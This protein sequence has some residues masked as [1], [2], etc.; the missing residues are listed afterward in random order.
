MGYTKVKAREKVTFFG[1]FFVALL[2]ILA[3]NGALPFLTSP[4]LGQAVWTTGF[5]QSFLNQALSTIYS[6]NFGI[7]EPAAIAF[8]LA[9]AFVTAVL[10]AAGLHAADAYSAMIAFWLIIAF[11]SAFKLARFVSVPP[12]LAVLSALAWCTMPMVWNHAGY[13]MVSTGIALLPLY[14][15]AALW[16]FN[17][18]Q[19][20][21]AS[22][23][24]KILKIFLF[25][26]AVCL[27][28][29]FM[30]GYTFM[31]FACGASIIAV[32]SFF[33]ETASIK[34]YS[35]RLSIHILSFGIAYVLYAL[36]LG[37]PQFEASPIDFFRGWGVDI[38]FWLI[39]S[40]GVHWIP[41]LLGLSNLRSGAQFFGDSSVWV[42][43]FALPVIL[44]AFTITFISKKTRLVLP[45]IL[46]TLFG[47][48]MAL[49]PS[50][51]F[52]SIKPAE[53]TGGQMMG[54][55]YAVAPTGT[56]VLSE[57]LPGFKNMRAS[58]RWQAL[59]V[60]GA[61]ALIVLAMSR[62]QRKSIIA[63][64]SVTLVFV[65]ILNLPNLPNKFV[66]DINHRTMFFDI[67]DQLVA[68]LKN[69]V[70]HGEKV[71]FLPWRNDFLVNYLA[72]KLDIRT[73]NIGGDKNLMEARRHWPGLLQQFQ[74]AKID[75]DFAE[76][77]ALVLARKEADAVILPYID[78][79]WAAHAWPAKL[80][81]KKELESVERKLQT[82]D[83][84]DVESSTY[85]SVIRLKSDNDNL[86]SAIA[87]II[88]ENCGL[89][90]LC[91]EA[92]EFNA[93][94]TATQVGIFENGILKSSHQR[95][96]LLY[97]P[98]RP[99]GAGEYLLQIHGRI[100]KPAQGWIDV[101]S[102]RGSVVHAKF[103]LNELTESKGSQL[104][105]KEIIIDNPLHDVEVRVFVT[106]ADSVSIES[107]ALRKN[108]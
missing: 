86:A 37:K 73:Y 29:V 14:L 34:Q 26:L 61:W 31:M 106:E 96:F 64:A 40:A 71:L 108:K 41:D 75:Q 36:Y 21:A 4:T 32:W 67:D 103:P 13:S 63:L 20:I 22:A 15:L 11:F 69:E 82:Y 94:I 95:G 46:I 100:D 7:P 53:Y 54:A 80:E 97:G 2:F 56:A 39:P 98:Y 59:G 88:D 91:V 38:A 60:L 5:S 101:V 65:I 8:G 28:A 62:G 78:M 72:A 12:Y 33:K 79:L 35:Y 107:Y 16:L 89:V 102:N 105:S 19:A 74:M 6:H 43:T 70:T 83:W 68:D 3:V 44:G 66:R 17:G 76:R 18:T 58:Y 87:Q 9:G 24:H 49:G 85:Y 52:N 1:V 25:Y 27:L 10:M 48:Y 81:Y 57:H 92:K 104:L 90:N 77:V 99:L 50:F 84:L 45:L 47:F 30:D 42:T 55:Q 51:K 93:D 23:Y